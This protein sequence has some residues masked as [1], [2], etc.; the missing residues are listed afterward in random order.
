MQMTLKLKFVKELL[1]ILLNSGIVAAVPA[2][3]SQTYGL[4]GLRPLARTK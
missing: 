1:C 2:K 3:E 4:V